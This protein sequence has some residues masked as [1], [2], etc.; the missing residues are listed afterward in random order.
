MQTPVEFKVAAVSSNTNA[1]G[2]Y[3]MFL[4]SRTGLAFAACKSDPPAKGAI[5]NIPVGEDGVIASSMAFHFEIPH[6]L[7]DAP[8]Y[9]VDALWTK[10]TD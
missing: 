9:V 5:I 1:F 8:Q 3:Q 7:D 6:K 10:Q 4:V 2:L